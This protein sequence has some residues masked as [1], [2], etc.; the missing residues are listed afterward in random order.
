MDYNAFAR[1]TI[2]VYVNEADR[3]PYMSYSLHGYDTTIDGGPDEAYERVWIE[4]MDDEGKDMFVLTP[5]DYEIAL[6]GGTILDR[7]RDG[8][9]FADAVEYAMHAY[10]APAASVKE[11]AEL[12]RK[13]ARA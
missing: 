4:I 12:A 8:D 2:D 5:I 1:K 9:E 13:Y 3:G 10:G 11:L 6:I 7:F